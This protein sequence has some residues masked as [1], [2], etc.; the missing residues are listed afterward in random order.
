[1]TKRQMWIFKYVINDVIYYYGKRPDGYLGIE[2]DINKLDPNIT[3]IIY[4]P[5][6]TADEDTIMIKNP[7]GLKKYHDLIKKV[8]TDLVVNDLLGSCDIHTENTG[9][10]SYTAENFNYSM[11]VKL[12]YLHDDFE[13][14][15]SKGHIYPI[16]GLASTWNYLI[17]DTYIVTFS[18]VQGF[19]TKYTKLE[20][21]HTGYKHSHLRSG[22][23]TYSG[24]YCLGT[25]DVSARVSNNT[26][27]E[28]L[29]VLY[30]VVIMDQFVKW[31]SIETQPH[32]KMV[33][34]I[35][36]SSSNVKYTPLKEEQ[37]LNMVIKPSFES[38][39]GMFYA[40]VEIP[41]EDQENID[42]FTDT[43]ELYYRN[44]SKSYIKRKAL[45]EY[46]KPVEPRE[47]TSDDKYYFKGYQKRHMIGYTAEEANKILNTMYIKNVYDT[48]GIEKELTLIMNN[49]IYN[50]SLE[51]ATI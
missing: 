47:M 42:I 24:N 23:L 33:T 40:T 34:I 26:S 35:P 45:L 7:S 31:E 49:D 39:Y 30:D 9:Q 16:K 20:R 32:I 50:P 8:I 1:M 48:S 5:D 38:S 19:R 10:M 15:N 51:E 28:D 21:D 13:I 46:F 44:E 37:L 17:Y 14:T 11:Y 36:T 22:E 41:K 27:L 25:S 4:D 43:N 2:T 6:I 12:V 29:D 18:G 3:H